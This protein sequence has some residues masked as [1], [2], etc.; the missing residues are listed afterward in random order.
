MNRNINTEAMAIIAKLEYD[1]N[2]IKADV[3]SADVNDEAIPDTVINK[4]RTMEELGRET[5]RE[6]LTWIKKMTLTD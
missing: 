6:Y 5:R 1:L 2:I 3:I 4:L